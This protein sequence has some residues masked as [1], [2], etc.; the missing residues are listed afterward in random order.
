MGFDI[1]TDV[2][3]WRQQ[4][5]EQKCCFS[6]CTGDAQQRHSLIVF[7]ASPAGKTTAS[8]S[9]SLSTSGTGPMGYLTG[10]LARNKPSRTPDNDGRCRRLRASGA[11]DAGWLN[12]V[13]SIDR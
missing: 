2:K 1:L 12:R 7:L 13:Q 11:R 10:L 4:S 9:E 3:Y 5:V 8:R 6:D